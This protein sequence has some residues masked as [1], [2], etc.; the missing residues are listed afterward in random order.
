MKQIR[1][2]ILL[3]LLSI[4][5]SPLIGQEQRVPQGISY[6]AIAQGADGRLLA[7][8]P[9]QVKFSLT[10][11]DALSNVYYV[12]EH[13]T[14][15]QADGS[16]QLVIGQGT[17]LEGKI[18]EV[19]WSKRNV[20]L[21]V[22]LA[23]EA[24]DYKLVSRSQMLAVP[25]AMVA[26]QAGSVIDTSQT[27][28]RNQSRYWLTAGNQDIK[29]ATHFLGTIDNQ[30][31]HFKTNGEDRMVIDEQG[32]LQIIN[33]VSKNKNGKDTDDTVYPLY[34]NGPRQ[35]IWIEIEQ[36]RTNVN[37]FMTF[38]DPQGTQGRIEGQ[39]VSEAQ[40]DDLYK[41]QVALYALKAASLTVQIIAEF[42]QGGSYASTGFAAGVS[43]A[44]FLTGG[45][46]ISEVA[47]FVADAASW[48][49]N[50]ANSAGV[51]FQSGAGDYA[52]YM[53]RDTLSRQLLPGEVIG[54]HAGQVSLQTSGA[55]H[56]SVVS[57]APAVLGGMPQPGEEVNY[58]KVAF[59][60]QV[61]VRISGA[62]NI[63]DYI[64]PSGNNDGLA[65]AVSPYAMKAGDY[66]QIIGIAWENAQ[67]DLI[68]MVKVAIGINANDL[69]A[70]IAALNLKV[71]KIYNYLEGK[72]DFTE[73]S[74]ENVNPIKVIED[75]TT[76][77]NKLLT[78]EEFDLI[79]E[80]NRA[81][82]E[83]VFKLSQGL[84]EA[85]NYDLNKIPEMKILFD[86]PIQ[87]LKQLRQ[88]PTLITQW[89]EIDR[90]IINGLN[91]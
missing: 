24:A 29:A 15:T 71:G 88:D 61:P 35:G 34:V 47:L 28:E 54:V 6:Q 84:V 38:R 3:S 16:F 39:T 87:F 75:G 55:Q 27:E 45:V 23:E 59:I 43:V 44:A 69:G 9:I 14:L 10:S 50:I 26:Q 21:G 49:A 13:Q 67:N 22:E 33:S 65:I 8:V 48:A 68:N 66:N 60:G 30:P 85:S 83:K 1:L 2:F 18:K 73:I 58:E 32:R 36:D 62:V 56:L 37:N 74:G 89:G 82:F 40:N 64:L 25:Y 46:L 12:E 11:K 4:S 19:P 63:G 51:A 76:K 5:I 42:V 52:E 20:Y 31:L 79:L 77:I 90:Q 53:L 80:E 41:L 7:E 81:T 70:E 57:T 86:D 78:D 91:K 17:V 72:A